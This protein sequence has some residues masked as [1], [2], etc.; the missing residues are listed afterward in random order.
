M[1]TTRIYTL[2]ALLMAGGVTML[3]N[4]TIVS[5]CFHCELFAMK[6]QSFMI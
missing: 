6:T 3:N 4:F 5:K 2:L 1:R